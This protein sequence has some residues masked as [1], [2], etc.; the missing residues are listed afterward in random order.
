MA[1]KAK[2]PAKARGQSLTEYAGLVPSAP[3]KTAQR[4]YAA[5]EALRT[6]ARAEEH[7]GDKRLMADVKKL[8]AEQAGRMS[9]IAK[10]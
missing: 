10:K 1:T 7:K 9:R 6:L 5:E 4:R 3:D 8:A 2:R